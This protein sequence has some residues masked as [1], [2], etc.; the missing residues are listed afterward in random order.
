[1]RYVSN[2]TS[3]SLY[4]NDNSVYWLLM[5]YEYLPV[6]YHLQKCHYKNQARQCLQDFWCFISYNELPWTI[7]DI[8]GD[9]FQGCYYSSGNKTLST[10][11]EGNHTEDKL[12]LQMSVEV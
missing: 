12:S 6:G 3:N 4:V 8:S 10:C 11:P 7:N 5:L 9:Q 2:T 1:M